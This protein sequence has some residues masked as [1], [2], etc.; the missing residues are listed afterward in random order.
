MSEI[1]ATILVRNLNRRIESTELANTDIR[2]ALIAYRNSIQ[3]TMLEMGYV[4]P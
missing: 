3:E 1:F 4:I 2:L